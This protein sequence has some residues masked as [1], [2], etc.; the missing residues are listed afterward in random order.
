MRVALLVNILFLITLISNGKVNAQSQIDS[1]NQIIIT[2]NNKVKKL[3]L[4]DELTK[5]MIRKNH[6][7]LIPNLKEYLINC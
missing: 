4:L 5:L 6:Q 2:T 3:E 1:L 7:K